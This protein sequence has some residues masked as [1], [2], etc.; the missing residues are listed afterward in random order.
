MA[1]SI[2]IS[3][4]KKRMPLIEPKGVL[5][6]LSLSIKYTL[7]AI[8]LNN[9]NGITN[10]VYCLVKLQSP[11]TVADICAGNRWCKTFL[12]LIELRPSKKSQHFATDMNIKAIPYFIYRSVHH[13]L[14]T[15]IIL[16]GIEQ[17]SNNLTRRFPLLY[18]KKTDSRKTGK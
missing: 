12:T 6:Y 15:Y 1:V 5:S 10:V 17:F 8:N 3:R 18:G 9:N 7:W 11:L 14:P 16:R 4:T 13:T 2:S